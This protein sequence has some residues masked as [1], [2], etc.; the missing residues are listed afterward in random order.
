F[1]SLPER[2]LG[3]D[4]GFDA[5]YQIRLCDIGRTW[6][7]R[8]TRHGARVRKGGTRRRPDVTIS[9]SADTWMR[10]RQGELSGVDAF[11]R[12]LLEVRGNLDQAVAFEG[13][14]RLPNGRPPLLRIHDIP[15]GRHRISTLTMGRGPDVLLLHG[16]GGTRASL[17]E[18]AATLSR[19][20]RVHAPDLPG[21]GSSSKPPLGAYDARWF[22]DIMLGLMDQLDIPW[23]HVVGNSLGGRIAIEIGLNAP[24]RTGALGLLCP[25]V[26]WV[27]RSLHPLVRAL[28][29]ELGMLPHAIRRS[30]ISMQLWS[31]FHDRDAID[32]AVGD[33]V[34]DEFRRIY[35][36]A[37]ARY[38]FWTAARNIYLEAPF[39]RHGFY[40]RLAELRPPALWMWGSHDPL[41]PAAFGRHVAKWLP[42]ARQI[43]ID[44]CGHVPQVERPGQT[45]D[46][47]VSFFND[48]ER[49]GLVPSSR[50]RA[51]AQ[52]A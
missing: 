28:R 11:G 48:A 50:P 49:A 5:T 6:E 17:F 20:Y 22:A 21:F 4:P 41:V 47:L 44:R 2:Y 16:L 33:L 1:A 36:S 18:T 51:D 39:G 9:T 19:R 8:C 43:T 14:F 42:D 15:V 31:M 40:P 24:E 7:V 30:V 38:A 23:A 29:P 34:V 12:R 45:N 13:M 27:R 46:L 10:L 26:A 37:G 25:A 52:A 32:P 3:A 35:N